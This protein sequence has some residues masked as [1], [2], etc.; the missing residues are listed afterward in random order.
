M[1]QLK[2]DAKRTPE[3]CISEDDSFTWILNLPL[4]KVSD[5]HVTVFPQA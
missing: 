3:T 5:A 2:L 4:G 1:A